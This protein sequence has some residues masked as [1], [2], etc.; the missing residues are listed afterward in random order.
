MGNAYDDQLYTP[1]PP[2]VSQ[3]QDF[4]EVQLWHQGIGE[5]GENI[6]MINEGIKGEVDEFGFAQRITQPFIAQALADKKQVMDTEKEIES[7]LITK[8]KLEFLR[9]QGLLLEPERQGTF[10]PSARQLQ[11]PI[12]LSTEVLREDARSLERD[13]VREMM[14]ERIERI[15]MLSDE[16]RRRAELQDVRQDVRETLDVRD[17]RETQR[18]IENETGFRIPTK[19]LEIQDDND[20]IER[21]TSSYPT[22]T[23]QEIQTIVS[24]RQMG[25]R[26]RRLREQK[27]KELTARMLGQDIQEFRKELRELKR[28]QKRG[29]L[30]MEDLFGSSDI[31]IEETGASSSIPMSERLGSV[32]QEGVNP[33][34]RR[35]RTVRTDP[36]DFV[37]GTTPFSLFE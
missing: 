3:K 11:R 2:M 36:S 32:I 22:L 30:T 31:E 23:P 27:Q 6:K 9:R 17:I 35:E 16:E 18:D 15:K 19:I 14:E 37:P 12:P 20:F 7:D 1:T 4:I 5:R 28:K 29:E 10:L 26:G 21:L 33:P 8:G 34:P 13:V 24:K 25:Q